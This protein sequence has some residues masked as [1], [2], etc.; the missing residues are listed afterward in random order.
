MS[1]RDD[2]LQELE[3]IECQLAEC[4]ETL[5][6]LR[7][8]HRDISEKIKALDDMLEFNKLKVIK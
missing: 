4:I 1:L 5:E 7:D 6:M 2:L 8:T 3:C